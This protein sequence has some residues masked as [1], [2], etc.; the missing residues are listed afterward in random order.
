MSYCYASSPSRSL[1][2]ALART[3]TLLPSL[4]PPFLPFAFLACLPAFP[5]AAAFSRGIRTPPPPPLQPKT[6][7]RAA[8]AARALGFALVSSLRAHVVHRTR[9]LAR[10][11][12]GVA[13][14]LQVAP[15]AAAAVLRYYDTCLLLGRESG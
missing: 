7:A 14:L 2:R 6:M 1:A 12:T 11:G 5:A 4:P 10:G 9:A 13:Y 15:P 3:G 8:A